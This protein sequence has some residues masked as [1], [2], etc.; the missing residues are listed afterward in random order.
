MGGAPHPILAPKLGFTRPTGRDRRNP[1]LEALQT[2]RSASEHPR[3]WSSAGGK[4]KH[5]LG[6]NAP[7]RSLGARRRREREAVPAF[8]GTTVGVATAR[9]P[10]SMDQCFFM[11][12]SPRS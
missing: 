6:E 11:Y 9:L 4:A 3:R 1:W 7:K 8:A 10:S 2:L 12:N 5:S